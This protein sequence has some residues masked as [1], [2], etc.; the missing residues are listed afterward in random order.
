VTPKQNL[1]LSILVKD[2]RGG[3]LPDERVAR[4][5]RNAANGPSIVPPPVAET[6]LVEFLRGC[7]LPT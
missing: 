5:V 3:G 1:L 6:E 4:F 2:L 7:D